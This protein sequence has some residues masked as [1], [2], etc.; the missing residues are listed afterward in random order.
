MK[1][2]RYLDQIIFGTTEVCFSSSYNVKDAAT[3]LSTVVLQPSPKFKSSY[4]I[5]RYIKGQN[6]FIPELI[7]KVSNEKVL[8]FRY[9]RGMSRTQF[10][11]IFNGKFIIEDNQTFLKGS[12]STALSTKVI[13]ILWL[14]FSIY[15]TIMCIWSNQQDFSPVIFLIPVI[16]ILIFLLFYGYGRW[17]SRDDRHFIS[18]KI[19]SSINEVPDV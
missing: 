2:F 18:E 14:G 12:F 10:R 6:I 8:V 11:P 4:F 7:G 1:F 9:R 17:V 19:K 3:H 5:S 16:L 15:L 13:T